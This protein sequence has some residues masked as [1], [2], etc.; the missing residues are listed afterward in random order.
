MTY[1]IDR[2]CCTYY[3]TI[4]LLLAVN[5]SYHVNLKAPD[6]D[7]MLLSVIRQQG[8]GLVKLSITAHAASAC[9]KQTPKN[10]KFGCVCLC[11]DAQGFGSLATHSFW[12]RNSFQDKASLVIPVLYAYSAELHASRHPSPTHCAHPR[13][14]CVRALAASPQAETVH[15]NT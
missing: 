13:F 6:I 4:A 3:C 15:R 10:T 8:G 2:V 11:Y 12:L 7:H 1:I 9:S 14:L 5:K